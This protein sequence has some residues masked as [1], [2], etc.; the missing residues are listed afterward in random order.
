MSTQPSPPIKEEQSGKMS[1]MCSSR[2]CNGILV[3]IGGIFVLIL[4]AAVFLVASHQSW[5]D[6]NYVP[7]GQVRIPIDPKEYKG[8]W[9]E[10]AKYPNSFQ[11]DCIQSIAEYTLNDKA[12]YIEVKNTCIGEGENSIRVGTGKAFATTNPGQLAVSFFS[13]FYGQYGVLYRE[14]NISVV[15]SS[16]RQY[17]WILARTASIDSLTLCRAL[18]A[19]EKAGY[20]ASLLVYDKAVSASE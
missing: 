15:G 1:P 20:D 11:T 16:D 13:G 5:I 18:A 4:V 19:V 7:L 2:L 6:A 14:P 9:Y 8:V 3:G 12:G 10:I 17:L